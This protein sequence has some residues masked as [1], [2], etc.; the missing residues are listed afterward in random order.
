MRAV[1][2]VLTFFYFSPLLLSLIYPF[3][4]GN[5]LSSNWPQ[6]WPWTVSAHYLQV[7]ILM[8]AL[9]VSLRAGQDG[10]RGPIGRIKASHMAALARILVLLGGLIMVLANY[11]GD[12][13]P[14]NITPIY[15]YPLYLML[16]IP[17]VLC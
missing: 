2:F 7:F 6:L 1:K 10:Q 15:F 5:T 11:T 13:P 17:A 14:L 16:I 9:M 4:I 3:L 12:I 8:A